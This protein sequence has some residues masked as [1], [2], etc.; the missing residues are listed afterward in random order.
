LATSGFGVARDATG[1]Y[2]AGLAAIAAGA[3][4]SVVLLNILRQQS[5]AAATRE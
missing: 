2:G 5:A 3:V 1:S 4:V